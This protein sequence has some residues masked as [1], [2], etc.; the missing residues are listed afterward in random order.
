[1]SL[2]IHLLGYTVINMRVSGYFL[3]NNACKCTKIW[4]KMAVLYICIM[5]DDHLA[6]EDLN[7]STRERIFL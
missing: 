5:E 2:K 4:L 7:E 3:R 1:M 6:S